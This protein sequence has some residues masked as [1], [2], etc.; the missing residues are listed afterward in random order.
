MLLATM[1]SLII[2]G[3]ELDKLVK[4]LLIALAR[5]HHPLTTRNDTQI[6]RTSL[7]SHPK[8]AKNHHEITRMTQKNT[9]LL[10]KSIQD[11]MLT[12]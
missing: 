7:D 6:F 12:N 5:L 1:L 2:I 11:I 3:Q 9:R 10:Q 8:N 4:F